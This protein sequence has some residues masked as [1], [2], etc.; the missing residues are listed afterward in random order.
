M[1]FS[2]VLLLKTTLQDCFHETNFNFSPAYGC[3]QAKWWGRKWLP[4]IWGG[5]G[6]PFGSPIRRGLCK[7]TGR[8]WTPKT[9]IAYARWQCPSNPSIPTRAKS[10]QPLEYPDRH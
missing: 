9:P 7:H 1:R 2:K 3:M 5:S 10:Y 8:P 6:V 4:G